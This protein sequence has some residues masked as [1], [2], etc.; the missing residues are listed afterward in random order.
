M[1]P[2]R[3]WVRE[4]GVACLERD[5]DRGQSRLRLELGERGL[6]L[7]RLKLDKILMEAQ[8]LGGSTC[9]G[10]DRGVGGAWE[11][12]HLGSFV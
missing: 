10:R 7:K 9:V 12:P 2:C 8:R 3:T 5:N 1:L 6:L 4:A 11:R